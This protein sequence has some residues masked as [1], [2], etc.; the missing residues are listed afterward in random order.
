MPIEWAGE[1]LIIDTLNQRIG[2]RAICSGKIKALPK[3]L[4]GIFHRRGGIHL[5]L[6]NILSFKLNVITI[7][8]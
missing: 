2:G 6:W 7:R 1:C 5:C 8:I 4:I 3:A